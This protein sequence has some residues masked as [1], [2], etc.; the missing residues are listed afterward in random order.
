MPKPDPA[1]GTIRLQLPALQNA[2]DRF[3]PAPLSAR[4]LAPDVMAYVLARAEELDPESPISIVVHLPDDEFGPRRAQILSDAIRDHFHQQ[5][6][7][8]R[9]ERHEVFRTGRQYLVIGLAVFAFGALLLWVLQWAAENTALYTF[10]RNS[11]V[12]LAWVVIWRPAEIFLYDWLPI[13]K[14][15]LLFDRIAAAPVTVAPQ[16]TQE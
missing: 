11:A 15:R 9:D 2:F 4:R 3:D 8:E 6:D 5:S 10:A 12:I 1:P 13:R 7:W 14:R 16:A